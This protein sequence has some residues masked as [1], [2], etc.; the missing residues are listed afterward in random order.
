MRC[1]PIT[2]PLVLF[3]VATQLVA[4]AEPTLG[5]AAT[6]DGPSTAWSVTA[7]LASRRM[8]VDVNAGLP[9]G[10]PWLGLLGL[11]RPGPGDV[12][13]FD[14]TGPRR[15]ENGSIG[16]FSGSSLSEVTYNDRGQARPTGR[17]DALGD[18]ITEVGFG[19]YSLSQSLITQAFDLPGDSD[20][21][22][23]A[24]VRF[25]GSF[26]GWK[27]LNTGVSLGWTGVKMSSGLQGQAFGRFTAV[28]H[29]TDYGYAYDAFILDTSSQTAFLVFDTSGLPGFETPRRSARESQRVVDR[30]DARLTSDLDVALNEVEFTFDVE[31]YITSR[32]AVALSVGPTLD[33]VSIDFDATARY[34]SQRTGRSLVQESVHDSSTHVVVGFMAQ[35]MVRYDLTPKRI[36]HLE[37]HAGYHWL[38]KV[39]FAVGD[40][41]G[42]IELSSWDV[43]VGIGR[44]F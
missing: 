6:F 31:R 20:R 2:H 40:S 17:L 27:G 39:D 18:P 26:G 42:D 30:I 5:E 37:A 35:M 28:E 34:V 3:S 19:S 14:G 44:R 4:S 33:A 25:S 10:I 32:F 12:G 22:L 41:G 21:G 7:G 16:G 9:Q 29:R 43:G 15:Y 24:F 1:S 13:L 23:G 38:P 8:S 11:G 36:W